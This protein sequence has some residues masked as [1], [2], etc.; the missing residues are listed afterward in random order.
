[1]N[2]ESVRC[3]VASE[4][5]ERAPDL[6]G[7][8][9]PVSVLPV[10]GVLDGTATMLSLLCLMHCLAL[11]VLVAVLPL[12]ASSFVADATFHRWMLLAVVPTSTLAFGMGYRSHRDVSMLAIGGVGLCLLAL[13]A[14][15]G[16][17]VGLSAF[18]D[19][20]L[21]VC[22]GL[23]LATAH[24]INRWRS[25]RLTHRRAAHQHGSA[26]DHHEPLNGGAD[27]PIGP[28]TAPLSPAAASGGSRS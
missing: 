8:R 19:T 9:R 18:G 17:L 1:M 2:D 5:P 13:A 6:P 4:A 28:L 20:A 25:H 11:P 3:S 12:V 15:G 26:C 24:G 10:V 14:Y 7:L 23:L 16:V 27:E 22:G 21:T